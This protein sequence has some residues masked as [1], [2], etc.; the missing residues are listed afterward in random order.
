MLM[1]NHSIV[2]EN[3]GEQII[4]ADTVSRLRNMFCSSMQYQKHIFVLW[5]IRDLLYHKI[6]GLNKDSIEFQNLFPLFECVNE[7][8]GAIQT[9][10]KNEKFG[11]WY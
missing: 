2:V 8:I 1:I 3:C 11:I 6:E 5:A 4:D 7:F 10:E 9:N